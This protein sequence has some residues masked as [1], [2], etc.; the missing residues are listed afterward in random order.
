[1]SKNASLLR[2]FEMAAFVLFVTAYVVH[3]RPLFD[4]LLR[5]SMGG[6]LAVFILQLSV[7]VLTVAIVWWSRRHM[8]FP[9]VVYPLTYTPAFAALIFLQSSLPVLRWQALLAASAMCLGWLVL[10]FRLR[11]VVRSVTEDRVGRKSRLL[12][13][14]CCFLALAALLG[15]FGQHDATL[16]LELTTARAIRRGDYGAVLRPAVRDSRESCLLTAERAY[17]VSHLPG[18][19]G[20]HLFKFPLDCC[21][22]TAG[23]ADTSVSGLPPSECLLPRRA[24]SA[25]T[26]LRQADMEA[27]IGLRRAEGEAAVDYLARA[28]GR[29][30][31]TKAAV[32]YYLCALLLDR[33]IEAFAGELPRFYVVSDST[34]LPFFY[35]EA[36]IV[37]VRRHPAAAPAYHDPAVMANYLDFL[38][39]RRRIAAGREGAY[40]LRFQYGDSYYWYYWK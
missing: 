38:D 3:Q 11:R 19:L 5:R 6:G 32:D 14:T 1:M 8:P 16:R 36:L 28:A 40:R 31:H 29:R 10:Y 18:G 30:P 4:L 20:E 23:R 25:R 34:V 39:L 37:N 13:H 7:V 21:S 24:D 22:A 12:G 27:H 15:I 2:R 33:N 35:R 26:L 9:K 17:A